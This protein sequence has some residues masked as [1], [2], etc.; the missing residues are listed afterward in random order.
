M[1]EL[2]GRYSGVAGAEDQHRRLRLQRAAGHR[3]RDTESDLAQARGAQ[4]RDRT[5]AIEDRGNAA[6]IPRGKEGSDFPIEKNRRSDFHGSCEEGDVSRADEERSTDG[7]CERGKS[8]IAIARDR[9]SHKEIN[10]FRCLIGN[11]C[12]YLSQ[13]FIAIIYCNFIANN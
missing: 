3:V 2:P 11:N 10:S 13:L 7:T 5:Q 9:V 4:D 6:E 8:T 1:Q 12:N